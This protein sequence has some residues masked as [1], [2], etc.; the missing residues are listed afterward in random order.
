[1]SLRQNEDTFP[2]YTSQEDLILSF[3]R[4]LR[5]RSENISTRSRRFSPVILVVSKIFPVHC[6]LSRTLGQHEL[7]AG[8]P[9]DFL[10]LVFD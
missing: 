10:S 4:I 9:A 1:M 3:G 8:D 7:P 2:L 6:T 5:F